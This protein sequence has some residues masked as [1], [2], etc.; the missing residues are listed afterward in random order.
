MC[1]GP[2]K[3][4]LRAWGCSFTWKTSHEIEVISQYELPP[5]VNTHSWWKSVQIHFMHQHHETKGRNCGCYKL[6][7]LGLKQSVFFIWYL[8]VVCDS[9]WKTR[10][11]VVKGS[12]VPKLPC[13]PLAQPACTMAGWGSSVDTTQLGVRGHA[14][15]CPWTQRGSGP[16]SLLGTGE[17]SPGH[18]G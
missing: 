18:A 10:C 6:L 9:L 3:G 2:A 12:Q 16:G 7:C 5:N 8:W 17:A 11:D 14:P 15:L 13:A 1:F 4:L